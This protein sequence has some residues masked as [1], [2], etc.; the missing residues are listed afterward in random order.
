MVDENKRRI[1]NSIDNILHI[2]YE[3]FIKEAFKKWKKES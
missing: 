3:F 1:Y 2:N